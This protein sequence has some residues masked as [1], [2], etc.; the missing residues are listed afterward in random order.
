MGS[1]NG[2]NIRKRMAEAAQRL[3]MIDLRL[4]GYV[5]T[6]ARH[7]TGWIPLQLRDLG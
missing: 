2:S 3:N 4:I 7:Y 1:G 5:I 6:N